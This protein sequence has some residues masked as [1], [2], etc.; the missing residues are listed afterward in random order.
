MKNM[1]ESREIQATITSYKESIRDW[2]QANSYI[3]DNEI[4]Y[5]EDIRHL[6]REYSDKFSKALQQTMSTPI[7][8]ERLLEII[9]D[10]TPTIAL[11]LTNVDDH[12]SQRQDKLVG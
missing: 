7:H 3:L 8:K 5:P 1:S 2:G 4:H 11:L 12:L 6:Y 10:I 9:N